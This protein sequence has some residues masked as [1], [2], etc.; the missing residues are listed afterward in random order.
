MGDNVQDG[1]I[2]GTI[3]I[4]DD[5]Q[6]LNH[7]SAIWSDGYAPGNFLKGNYVRT[8]LLSSLTSLV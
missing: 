2:H 7:S 4:S 3:R 6:N 1:V 8:I 5:F